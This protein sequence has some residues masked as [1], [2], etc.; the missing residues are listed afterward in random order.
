M[1][2]TFWHL[3]SILGSV[4]RTVFSWPG[5]QTR[6]HPSVAKPTTEKTQLDHTAIFHPVVA[7]LQTLIEQ[8]ADLYM[9]F[10]Q[11]FEQIPDEPRNRHDPTGRPQASLAVSEV[12]RPVTAHLT[13]R[14]KTI[15]TCSVN[16][17]PFLLVLPSLATAKEGT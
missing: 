3:P 17:T 12:D 7:E 4:A 15:T 8:D 16:S 1:P 13:V 10:H 5:I 2:F 14:S 6:H 9:A 11:M